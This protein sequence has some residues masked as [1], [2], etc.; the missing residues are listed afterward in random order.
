MAIEIPG[1]DRELLEGA[2]DLHLHGRPAVYQRPFDEIELARQAR[3]VGMRA[4]LPKCHH[5]INA[6]RA[7]LVMKVVPGIEVYGGVVLNYTVGGLNPEA[8]IAA[9]HYGAKQV[10]MPNIHAAH[11]IKIEGQAGYPNKE[12]QKIVKGQTLQM[13]GITI[14]TPEGEV[15]PE[16]YEILDLIAAADVILGTSHLSLEEQYILVKAA[17]SAGVKKILVTHPE[18]EVTNW[19]L[20]DQVKLADM[21]AIM[22][23]CFSV[24][25]PFE[26]MV[27]PVVM[28][29]NIRG[30]GAS[31]CVMATDLGQPENTNPIEGFRQFMRMMMRFDITEKEIEIMAKRNPA[32][33]LGLE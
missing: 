6:D 26:S 30:V 15:K 21:G 19:S 18:W 7:Q 32:K 33:L 13:E 10:W 23:H 25:M 14:L 1:E 5:T 17:R 16:V 28:A 29:E 20:E 22:E 4:I 31:R 8:V 24:C 9:L 2:I 27:N 11:H 3:S 12:F